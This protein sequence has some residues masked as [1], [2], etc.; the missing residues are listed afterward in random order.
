MKSIKIILILL[1]TLCFV[2]ADAQTYNKREHTKNLP[3]FEKRFMHFG[4][5][6]GYNI[7]NFVIKKDQTD[8]TFN[9]SLMILEP[10]T[11]PGFNLGIIS[12]LHMGDYF[13]LR[14]TPNLAFSS[15]SLIYT[16]ET[17]KGIETY[18]KD[19]ESTLINFPLNIK[20]KSVRLN[21]FSAYI[22]GG[23]AYTLDLAS[24]ADA[25]NFSTKLSD[26]I[27]KLKRDDIVGQIGF[28]TDFYLQ[29]FKFGIELKMSYGFFNLLE[30]DGTA[31]STPIG[32]L[33]SK[34]FL[35]SFTFEG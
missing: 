3:K 10:K 6:L 23:A 33:R 12:E 1:F 5:L 9:D 24:N 20:Y 34:M 4:F 35:L 31:L 17:M 32:Q 8:L 13:G 26:I 16:F 28:G 15:R 25:D 21:N 22:I 7:A 29:Y 19:I 11:A 18:Q 14:F 2:N 27:V 30:D